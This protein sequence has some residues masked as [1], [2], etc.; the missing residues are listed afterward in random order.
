M[1]T[2]G[3]A[4]GLPLIWGA[5]D[6]AALDGFQASSSQTE[7]QWEAKFRA[8]PSPDNAREYM[9]RL[10]A[11]PHHVGSPY[12]KDNAEWL[13]S[14]F[15]EWGF[16]AHIENFEVLFPTPKDNKLELIAPHRFVASLSEPPIA[17][18]PTSS[19]AGEQLPAYNAYSIDGD[20]TGRLIYVNYGMPGDY[21][22]LARYG[23]SVKGAIVIAR[24]GHGWR[25]VKPKV[26]GEHGA[27]GCIIYSDPKDDGYTEGDVFPRGAW[28]P[29]AGIQRGSVMDTD[30]PGDPL[31][32]GV[33]SVPGAKRLPVSGAPTI[34]KIPVLPISYADAQPLLTA[35]AGR[36]APP[37]WRGGLP[38]TYHVGPGPAKVHL[39]VQSN[40]DQKTLYDVIAKIPGSQ[41]PDEWVIRGNHHDAWVNGA[42]DP[43]SGLITL[44]EEARSYGELLKQGWRPKRTIIYCAWDGE[45]PGLLG[46]TEWVEAHAEELSQHAVA[47]FNSDTNG[48][49]FFGAEGSHTLQKF[50]NDVARDIQDPEKDMSVWQRRKLFE[51][52]HARDDEERNEIRSERDLWIGALG[53]G[54]DYCAFIHHLGIPSA[55]VR[56]GGESSGGVYHSIYDDFY[57]FTHFGDPTFEYSRTESQLV[58]TAIIRL[59]SADLLPLDFTDFADA[60]RKFLGNVQELL[61]TDQEKFREQDREIEEGVFTAA[62][63]PTKPLLAPPMVKAPPH[64]NFAPLENALDDLTASAQRYANAVAKCQSNGLS[65]SAA[66]LAR[67][68]RILMQAGPALTDPTGLPHR[69]WFKNQIYAPGAYTGYEAKP[70]PGVLEAMD[71][72]NWAEA[73]SQ[74]PRE[75]AALARETK[76]IDEATAALE[77]T[78]ADAGYRYFA[79]GQVSE[80]HVQT[81]PSAARRSSVVAL[82]GGGADQDAAF[83]W[84]CDQA[85]G[86][87][88][89]VLRASGTDAYNGYVK[90][91]CPAMNAVETLVITSRKGAQQPFVLDKIRSACTLFI[92]GGS[93]DNYVNFWQGTPVEDAVNGVIARGAP[94]GG[95][96]AGLAILGQYAFSALNDTIR[97]HE[98]LANPFDRRVTIDR[99]FLHVPHMQG[100][101]TDSH[102]VARDRMGRLIVFLARISQDGWTRAPYGIGIDE[103]TAVLMNANGESTVSGHGAAYFLHAPGAPEQCRPGAPLTYRKI[104][105]YRLRPGTGSFNVASWEGQGGTAYTLSAVNGVLQS[106]QP[107]GQIY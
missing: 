85:A 86:G 10:T 17:V 57:W 44:L 32:P 60:V 76:V 56:F 65:L 22:E 19:Q 105:V 96:S 12:D 58:G 7:R 16:D 71:R 27:V 62:S 73:E 9:R 49:G 92:S 79:L 4:F 34:T 5:G 80:E 87:N 106:A 102:F 59:A 84:M 47:Y 63:D 29:P 93:Q 107:D 75:A 97:S 15:K 61:K 6:Q 48:R 70:L 83:E 39:K 98:A 89:V 82:M 69:P 25:G 24:Y 18:D 26:A 101:I 20:V 81:T 53:D 45:E 1:A 46:S 74:I 68:N 43:V 88:F 33:A 40:W 99:D 52:E 35:L 30:Y 78:V 90:S 8:L 28:R 41:F 95:T 42:E 91:V 38:I 67:V 21:E 77:K 13:L 3:L 64:F 23:V 100:K 37:N 72:K 55:D 14:K 54:S 103:K 36:V 104:S 50:I 31:T 51:I 2:A 94:I 11:H 66:D